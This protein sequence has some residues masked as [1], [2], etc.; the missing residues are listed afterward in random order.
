M[1][2]KLFPIVT[3]LI[4]GDTEEIDLGVLGE[5]GAGDDELDIEQLIRLQAAASV[6]A[7][8]EGRLHRHGY[9]H[10]NEFHS[11]DDKIPNA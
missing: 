7:W 5:I 8:L 1:S 10:A 4:Y 2:K 9:L 3:H 11:P 6:Q